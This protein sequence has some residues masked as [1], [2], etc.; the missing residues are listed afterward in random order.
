MSHTSLLLDVTGRSAAAIALGAGIGLERQWRLRTAGIRTNALVSVGSALFVLLGVVPFGAAG[1]TDPTRVAAQVVSGI[2]FLGAGVILRDGANIRGLTTAATL[3]CAAAVGS[4]CGAGFELVALIGG[5]AIVGTNTLLRP[6]SRFI[7]S[8]TRDRPV[9]D[10]PVEE[11]P[12]LSIDYVLE[13]T[14]SDKSEQRVRGL[15]LQAVSLPEYTLTSLDVRPAKNSQMRLVA[16]L[17]AHAKGET[18][19]L[20]MAVQRLSLE[21]KVTST[22]WWIAESD[23]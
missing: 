5:A 15:V 1:H 7:N 19:G 17:S 9:S 16:A 8:R 18:G 14:T 3:W 6:L 20:E 2:G 13:V 22:R 11:V 21:P 10:A 23:D 4:L 12:S